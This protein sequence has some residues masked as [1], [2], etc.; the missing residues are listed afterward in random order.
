MASPTIAK[1]TLLTL[2]LAIGEYAESVLLRLP[3][4]SVESFTQLSTFYD[5]RA[6]MA[7]WA[8]MLI[9][10]AGCVPVSAALLNRGD[11]DFRW[12]IG[13]APG[14]ALGPWRTPAV[15]TMMLLVTVLIALPVGSLSWEGMNRRAEAEAL[16]RTADSISWSVAYPATAA[17]IATVI[18][19]LLAREPRRASGP[20]MLTLF[21]LP[22][23]LL[24]FASVLAWKRPEAR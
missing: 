8:P 16:S 3:F 18:G 19:F 12:K 5:A 17:T 22:G 24:D 15:A 10:V 11:R 4:F 13:G 14:I 1:A 2:F 6:A 23:M 20:T 21:T 9:A 7:A